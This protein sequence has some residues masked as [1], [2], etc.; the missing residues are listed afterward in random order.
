MTLLA[1]ASTWAQ[2]GVTLT[3]EINPALVY[4]RWS[5]E[6]GAPRHSTQ[7]DSTDS[8]LMFRGSEDLGSG[9]SANFLLSSGLRADTGTGFFCGRDCWVGLKGRFGALRLGHALPIYDDV[10]FPWYF[11]EAAGNHNPS[12]LWANCGGGAGLNEGCID[13]YLSKT[14]RYDTPSVGG[15]SASASVSDPSDDLAGP[16]RRAKVHAFGGEYRYGDWYVGAAHQR[17]LHV[18]SPG[19]VDEGTT[20]SMSVKA[21]INLGVGLEHL[22]YSIDSGGDVARSYVGV[23]AH[24]TEGAHTVWA[25]HAFAASG[26]GSAA[27]GD[28]VNAVRQLEDSGAGMSTLGY[29]YRFSKTVQ[30]YTYWNEIRNRRNGRYSFDAAPLQ[31]G[32]RISALAFG[33][34]KRF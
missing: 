31:P 33:M 27:S 3:G 2:S 24:R 18:R 34:S 9:M 12:A 26:H 22:R 21:W 4:R 19:S 6:A 20:L 28:G 5:D 13:N 14:V 1:P 7:L 8:R 25:N 29:R 17:Q 16:A 10:S 15:F 30:A 23:L 32:S 11:I